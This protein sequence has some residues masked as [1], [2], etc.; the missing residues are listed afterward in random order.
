ESA[1]V[2]LGVSLVRMADA[3]EYGMHGKVHP[4]RVVAYLSAGTDAQYAG[5]DP[6]ILEAMW[7]KLEVACSEL[8]AI[9][10]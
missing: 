10:R 7:P 4:S 1:G 3:I 2:G 8:E 9:L 5:F 6:T